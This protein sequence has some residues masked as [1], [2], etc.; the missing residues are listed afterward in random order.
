MNA[1][2][3]ALKLRE[4]TCPRFCVD[5][6]SAAP[7]DSLKPGFHSNAIACVS[8]G[9]RLRYDCVWMEIGLNR[10]SGWQWEATLYHCY[11]DL[12]NAEGWTESFCTRRT[13]ARP[14]SNAPAQI[15]T[16]ITWNGSQPLRIG[17]LKRFSWS[18]S[19]VLNDVANFSTNS[20]WL[21]RNWN[22]ERAELMNLFCVIII[23]MM[24]GED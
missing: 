21:D 5:W 20:C 12:M 22:F 10:C 18:H 1:L 19:S 7:A 14:T 11:S 13:T 6:R 24:I 2:M 16:I 9:F 8:C 15:I 3:H 17:P 4:P 23:T